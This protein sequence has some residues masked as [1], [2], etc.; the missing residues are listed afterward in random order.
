MVITWVWSTI[1]PQSSIATHVRVMVLVSGQVKASSTSLN[2]TFT[3]SVQ[4]SVAVN[5]AAGGI[6]S[7]QVKASSA[8]RASTKTGSVTSGA[9]VI[10]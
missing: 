8:G 1:L 10:T 7:A 2:T 6:A 9:M 4:S 3:G 5:I